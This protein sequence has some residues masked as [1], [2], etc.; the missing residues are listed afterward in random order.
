MNHPTTPAPDGAANSENDETLTE[1]NTTQYQELEAPRS[2]AW[3]LVE[4]LVVLLVL[5]AFVTL[6]RIKAGVF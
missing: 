4:F 2:P 3:V 6:L 1:T 5:A